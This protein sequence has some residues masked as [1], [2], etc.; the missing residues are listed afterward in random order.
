[1]KL[2]ENAILLPQVVDHGELAPVDP[3]GK[4]RQQH[5]QRRIQHPTSVASK[6]ARMPPEKVLTGIHSTPCACSGS[7]SAE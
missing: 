2:S 3:P 1:V 5:L 4:H 7:G 6:N